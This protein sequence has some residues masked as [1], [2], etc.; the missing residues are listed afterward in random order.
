[1]E[2]EMKEAAETGATNK[3]VEHRFD[4]VVGCVSGDHE[5]SAEFFRRVTEKLVPGHPRGSFETVP[6]LCCGRL[7]VD[8]ACFARHVQLDTEFRQPGRVR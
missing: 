8:P 6:L 7:H 2:D 1:V 5:S 3:P 4:L